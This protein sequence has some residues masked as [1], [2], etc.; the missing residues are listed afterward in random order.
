MNSEQIGAFLDKFGGGSPA[1]RMCLLLMFLADSLLVLV[2]QSTVGILLQ[3]AHYVGYGMILLATVGVIDTVVNDVLPDR[4]RWRFALNLRHFGLM[5][6]C[7]CYLMLIF[8]LTQSTLSWW[9]LPNYAV[10]AAFFAWNA[11]T[12]IRRRYGPGNTK[13]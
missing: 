10:P 5:A 9:V 7:V 8:L 12:D 1:F 6:C 2:S 11:F 13:C 4:F 3:N